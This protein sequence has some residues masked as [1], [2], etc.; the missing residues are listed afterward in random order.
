M[1]KTLRA[2][3][4]LRKPILPARNGMLF[5]GTD[6]SLRRDIAVF[7]SEQP[8]RI[9]Q[10]AYLRLLQTV[11]HYND[12]RFLH[13]LDVGVED[14][15]IYAVLKAYEGNPLSFQ[16]KKTGWSLTE[17]AAAV[18]ELGLGIVDAASKHISGFSILADNVWLDEEGRL[19][20]INYWEKTEDHAQGVRGLAGLCY[21]LAAG[22]EAIPAD[23]EERERKLRA[24]LEDHGQSEWTESFIDLL[25]RSS[26]GS[27]TLSSFID[28]LAVLA[29]KS[30]AEERPNPLLA[31]GM[32][33]ADAAFGTLQPAVSAALTSL[34]V[35]LEPQPGGPAYPA[36][37]EL[38]ANRSSQ[39]FEEEQEAAEEESEPRRPVVRRVM[40][41]TFFGFALM[42]VALVSAVGVF[43]LFLELG[44]RL[45]KE[46]AA[47]VTEG[48]RSVQAVSP[49]AQT[50]PLVSGKV[51]EQKQQPAAPPVEPAEEAEPTL[52]DDATVPAPKL[53]G[54]NK[55]EAEKRALDSGLKY[56][57]F[58]EKNPNSANTVFR[59]SPAPG[60]VLAKGE[61]VSF[62]ISKGQ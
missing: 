17:M 49:H 29:G 61:S 59:Q 30:L 19:K 56:E 23:G 28:Q 14:L 32:R 50:A 53:V 10:Q 6:L 20:I 52:A 41:K 27:E 3:Y 22:S 47:E 58:L 55:Q 37:A 43:F 21:Q 51:T 46:P 54:L 24:A 5:A 9:E 34:R 25:R 2:R 15:S 44:A 8:S 38:A 45:G 36:R 40:R 57:Y 7:V 31:R 4:V 12:N 62:W 18:S 42:G 39:E 1:E 60:T 35:G 48:G 33:E 26:R 11:A 13:L 16:L